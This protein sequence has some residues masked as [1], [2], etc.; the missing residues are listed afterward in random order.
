M[1]CSSRANFVAQIIV[2]QKTTGSSADLLPP[3]IDYLIW[4]A[5]DR[6]RLKYRQP[7]LTKSLVGRAGFADIRIE[8]T[9][10][11]IRPVAFR[12]ILRVTGYPIGSIYRQSTI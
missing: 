6:A 9:N 3:T 11:E 7:Y 10:R 8:L 12:R 4:Y 5:R 1:R 2:V